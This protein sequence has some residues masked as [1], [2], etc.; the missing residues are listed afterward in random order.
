[1]ISQD[2]AFNLEFYTS[3]A[4]LEELLCH[5]KNSFSYRHDESFER[6]V[7]ALCELVD[8]FNLISFATLDVQNVT[9]MI[10]LLRVIDKA[11]GYLT[12]GGIDDYNID[13]YLEIDYRASLCVETTKNKFLEG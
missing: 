13:E 2:L 10:K 11:M 1:M 4:S 5:F 9:S 7:R 8:D 3:V 6:F 12:T